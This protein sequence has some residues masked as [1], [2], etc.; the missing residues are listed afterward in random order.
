[1]YT[2]SLGTGALSMVNKPYPSHSHICLHALPFL[3]LGQRL[4]HCIYN[5]RQPFLPSLALAL[6]VTVLPEGSQ[7]GPGWSALRRE[8]MP[9]RRPSPPPG[10]TLASCAHLRGP[11][12]LPDRHTTQSLSTSTC[13]QAMCSSADLRNLALA[14][15]TDGHQ[16]LWRKGC[17]ILHSA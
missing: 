6:S 8:G 16:R 12:P 11:L 5:A 2:L 15:R 10:L 4:P 13:N 1:M 3:I 7:S 9:P 17:P 14:A